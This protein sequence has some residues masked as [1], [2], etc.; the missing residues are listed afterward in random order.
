M[1]IMDDLSIE[2]SIP[3]NIKKLI[4]PKFCTQFLKELHMIWGVSMHDFAYSNV[5]YCEGTAGWNEALTTT[6][7]KLSVDKLYIY[8]ASLPWYDSDL[9][10]AELT[11][12]LVEQKLILPTPEQDEI[13]RQSG[14]SS[15]D[16]EICDGC[17][18]YFY[19][20]DLCF[21]QDEND[22]FEN[23]YLCK[24]CMNE[25][26]LIPLTWDKKRAIYEVLEK[27]EGD[28]FICEKC[29]NAHYNHHKGE[30][31]CLH[32]EQEKVP[33][34]TINKYYRDG[35]ELNKEYRYNILKNHKNI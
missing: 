35:I 9:F 15:D 18:Q 22:A 14:V 4:T 25:K 34:T 12:M 1:P 6:C 30:K 27:T 3:Q 8:Y 32:C 19:K 24:Q 33:N 5:G 20:Q 31:Y 26:T 29:G 11:E 28:Y 16:I 7:R 23:K 10:D 21:L 2:Y 13:A 17:Y